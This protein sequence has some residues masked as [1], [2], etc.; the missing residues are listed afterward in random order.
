[1]DDPL[2]FWKLMFKES[3]DQGWPQALICIPQDA[4]RHDKRQIEDVARE[5]GFS[6]MLVT[7]DKK[8]EYFCRYV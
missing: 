8:N 4:Y 7:G 1:M 2:E 6:R 5:H 3:S